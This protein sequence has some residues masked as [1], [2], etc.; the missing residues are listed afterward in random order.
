MSLL[1]VELA[2]ALPIATSRLLLATATIDI[3]YTIFDDELWTER[4]KSA[5]TSTGGSKVYLCTEILSD[6]IL[7]TASRF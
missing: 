3:F 5:S 7:S 4:P 6:D 2:E 1:A